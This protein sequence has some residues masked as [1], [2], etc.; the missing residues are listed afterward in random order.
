MENDS[1]S[2]SMTKCQIWNDYMTFLSDKREKNCER[3]IAENI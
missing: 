3:I 2:I 1:C